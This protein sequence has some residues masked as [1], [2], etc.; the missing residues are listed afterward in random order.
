M[1][2]RV[3]KQNIFTLEEIEELIIS[4]YVQKV[5]ERSVTFTESFKYLFNERYQAISSPTDIFR[6]MGLPVDIIGQPRIKNFSRLYRNY[7]NKV[8]DPM[9]ILMIETER[10][11]SYQ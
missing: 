1:A 7:I 8:D 3:Y 11:G 6:E 4:P 5:T 2:K 10:Q 9:E